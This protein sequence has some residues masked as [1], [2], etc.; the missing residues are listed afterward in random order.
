MI[1]ASYFWSN[2]L[3]AFIFGHG[4]MTITLANLYMLTGLRTTGPMQPYGYLSAGSKRLAKIADYTRW[5]SYILNHV[6]DGSSISERE[7]MAFLN[8]WLERFIFCGSSCGPTYNHK[9]IAEHLAVGAAIPLG[10]YLLG[11]AYH[12]MNQVATQLLKNEPVHT[13]SG[14][15]WLIQL[16][17]NLYMHKMVRSCRY[18]K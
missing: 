16:W 6:E 9:L 3:N 13:I 10:K 7:Y 1:S 5:A 2:A 12:L 8:M 4:L 14:H 11:A 18:R 17:I 15:W